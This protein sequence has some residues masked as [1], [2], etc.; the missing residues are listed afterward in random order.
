MSSSFAEPWFSPCMPCCGDTTSQKLQTLSLTEPLGSSLTAKTACDAHAF[1]L[2]AANGSLLAHSLDDFLAEDEAIIA[3]FLKA[4]GPPNIGPIDP[5]QTTT[6][7]RSAM[8]TLLYS[9]GLQTSVI[10]FPK[11][12]LQR[13]VYSILDE[14][15][16]LFSVSALTRLM[17]IADIRTSHG[18]RPALAFTCATDVQ[19]FR[20][21]TEADGCNSFYKHTTPA[22]AWIQHH[23]LLNNNAEITTCRCEFLHQRSYKHVGSAKLP[24]P[25]DVPHSDSQ[26]NPCITFASPTNYNINCCCSQTRKPI[27]AQ[28]FVK[29]LVLLLPH[30]R[31]NMLSRLSRDECPPP[32]MLK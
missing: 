10:P 30:R 29:C 26:D 18:Q 21:P 24:S 6:P 1:S 20:F 16:R 32:I 8:Q 14:Q 4:F 12:A 3:T 13:V 27:H 25:S 23:H 15:F 22:Y 17:S 2:C 28:V 31:V 19:P 5:F 11:K 9:L 7:D